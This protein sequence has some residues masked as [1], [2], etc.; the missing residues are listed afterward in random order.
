[1]LSFMMHRSMNRNYLSLNLSQRFFDK[2]LHKY[3]SIKV[4]EQILLLT[5]K[6]L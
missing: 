2:F 4:T 3:V 1:M 5:Q 6:L